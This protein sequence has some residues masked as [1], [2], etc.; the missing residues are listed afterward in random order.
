MGVQFDRV[1]DGF[2]VPTVKE[3]QGLATVPPAQ[4]T[5]APNAAAPN[6]SGFLVSHAMN[7]AFIAVNRALKAG[8][9][10]YLLRAPLQANGKTY[11]AGTFWIASAAGTP[12]MLQELARTQGVA[13]DAVASRP[14]DAQKLT[15][16]RIAL[17]DQYGGSMPSGWTR[18]LFERYDF[19]FQLVYPK[20]L[21]AGNLSAKYD[22]IVFPSGTVPAPREG[23]FGGR[24]GGGGFGGA[25]DTTTI[26]TEFRA[27][28]GRVT[29]ERT[30]PQIRKFL[31]DGGTVIAVGTSTALGL[32]LG[33]PLESALTETTANGQARDL[34]ADKFYIPGSVLRVAVD[35]TRPV[36]YGV[37]AGGQVDVFYDN[38]PAFR[39]K[40]DAAAQGVRP[41]AWFAS[42][43]PL[44]SGWAWGQAYLDGAVEA[45]EAKVGKGTLYLFAPEITFRGQPYGTFKWLFNGIY[46][47]VTAGTAM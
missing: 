19:P 32:H 34:P 36:S 6:A 40:S 24:G 23:G 10:V 5:S 42:K 28:L 37:G 43:T 29:V 27:W 35:T 7:N 33:L 45:A 8:A 9:D 21:D 31:D 16:K 30:V 15:P 47:P 22:V 18:Y 39:L 25:M 12:A 46:T 20:D 11:P 1:L 13:A 26:P 14:A 17:F 3:V 4:A 38:S 44:R 2:D 41:L